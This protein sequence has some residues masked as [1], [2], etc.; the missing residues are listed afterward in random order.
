MPYAPCAPAEASSELRHVAAQRVAR[1]LDCLLGVSPTLGQRLEVG[2]LLVEGRE[3]AALQVAVGRHPAE[4]VAQAGLLLHD[5]LALRVEAGELA[6]G[7]GDGLLQ[8]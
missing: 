1:G 7:L 3:I 4:V 2:L 5:L 6:L 8:L